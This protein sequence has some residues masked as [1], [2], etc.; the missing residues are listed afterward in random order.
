MCGART[1]ASRLW[2]QPKAPQGMEMAP[3]AVAGGVESA[4]M[5]A[6]RPTGG[7]GAAGRLV[8]SKVVG[9]VRV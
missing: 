1:P 2:L 5:S 6:G 9:L 7:V 3:R 4:Q 8:H